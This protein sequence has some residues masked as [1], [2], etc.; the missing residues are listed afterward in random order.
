MSLGDAPFD[1]R[2]TLEAFSRVLAQHGCSPSP[3]LGGG[4]HAPKAWDPSTT[5]TAIS[6]FSSRPRPAS[7][8]GG[9]PKRQTTLF[10]NSQH[11]PSKHGSWAYQDVPRPTDLEPETSHAFGSTPYL[12]CDLTLTLALALT[13]SLAL[14]L[15]LS[16]ALALA[17]TLTLARTRTLTP[18]PNPNP[19]PHQ[20]RPAGARVARVPRAA[21]PD[22]HEPR[23]PRLPTHR[24]ADAHQLRGVARGPEGRR[25]HAGR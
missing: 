7:S 2:V 12:T 19:N 1:G 20:V 14:A 4:K 21:Q 15:T 11:P 17:R 25:G 23:A 16:L 5:V 8:K 3:A 9:Q 18:N 22:R 6:P 10:K 13:L 24:V